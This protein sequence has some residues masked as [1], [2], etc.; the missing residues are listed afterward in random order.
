MIDQVSLNKEMPETEKKSL[1]VTTLSKIRWEDY[2][3][4]LIIHTP[5]KFSFPENLSDLKRSPDECL[6]EIVDDKIYRR[7]P[8]G[9]R[10]FYS[11]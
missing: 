2:E 10:L 3:D 4:K 8:Q 11:R 9:T 6:F 5:K 1:Y 7:F